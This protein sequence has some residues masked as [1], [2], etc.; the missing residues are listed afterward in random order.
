MFFKMKMKKRMFF[1]VSVLLLSQIGASQ[2]L[3]E[4]PIET[5]KRIG[6]KLIQD[7][8][9]AY[10]LILSPNNNTFNELKKVDFGRT[11]GLHKQAVAYAYTQISSL[12]DTVMRIE[13][14][15]NDACK[16]WCN[17]KL[18]YK[19]NGSHELKLIR[20]ERGVELPFI[21]DIELKKGNN[22][23]LIKSETLGK[24]WC[25]FLQPLNEKDAVL[26]T[27]IE[28]PEIGLKHIQRIDNKISE[29]NN[30]LV[31]GPFQAGIDISHEPENEIKFG[32]MYKGANT[33]VSWT[34]PKIEILGDVISSNP[35]GSSYQW[36][37]HNGG[38]AWAMQQLTEVTKEEKYN[39]WANNFCDYHMEGITFVN[40]QVNNLKA[41]NSANSMVIG[42]SLLDFTL[43]PSLPLIYRL[44]KEK[45]FRNYDLYKSFIQ[46]MLHYAR[47]DQIRSEGLSN[48]NRKTPEKYTVWTDDMFMGIPFL[49]QAGLYAGTPELQK[50]Y[51]DDAA[52]QILDFSKHVWDKDA[53]LYMH[54]NYTSRPIVKLPHWS[55]ANGWAIWA[56]TEVLMALPSNHPKY[57]AILNQ[58][59]AHVNSIIKYQDESG[60]WHNVIDRK[61][62][63]NEV[64][65]TAIFNMAIARGIRYS[66][67]D[68]K[69]YLPIALKSWKAI[70]SEVDADGTVH[71]ICIGTM[72][73]EDIN[74]YLNRPL[75]DNDTHGSFAV[76]FAGIEMQRILNET[77]R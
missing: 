75:I 30:W 6:D 4:A 15:H 23:L 31:I 38:V 9:F 43:A 40:Y 17:K 74:Y 49:I 20:E 14:D 24:G 39:Q 70:A 60:F 48:F 62:S 1:F 61:E 57:L 10:K 68:K 35:W 54:A 76:I 47:F 25:V 12:R 13:I 26:S 29:L 73:S 19:K 51:F 58:Y 22:D 32:Y 27:Q 36:N 52:N 59:K 46:K 21:F 55:R 66:W 69:K 53:E 2:N 18:I 7:T 50:I 8:P 34:I 3:N 56:I 64:S 16:I 42:S 5:V 63:P 67:L 71:D 44:R 41:V 72:C 11:F 28:Y 77:I 65:G 45:E 33:L 37:Y